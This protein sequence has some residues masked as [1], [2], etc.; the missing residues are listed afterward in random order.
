M[1][2]LLGLGF[3]FSLIYI[4]LHQLKKRKLR[5]LEND[6]KSSW[7]RM[8]RRN[9][10][11]ILELYGYPSKIISDARETIKESFNEISKNL[12]HSFD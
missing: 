1:N 6:L 4:V 5:A 2:W 7:G 10:I 12:S 8:K 9:A 11:K 3:L